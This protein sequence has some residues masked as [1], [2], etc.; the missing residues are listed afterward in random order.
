[1][2]H[3]PAMAA[4][5]HFAWMLGGDAG[6]SVRVD[7]GGTRPPRRVHGADPLAE[8]SLR[9]VC[10]E[11]TRWW[12]G[13]RRAYRRIGRSCGTRSRQRP[14]SSAVASS[15][16]CRR[17]SRGRRCTDRPPREIAG[18]PQVRW[19]APHG[20]RHPLVG[21]QRVVQP[22]RPILYLG[23]IGLAAFT[24]ARP[25]VVIPAVARGR[26]D[27]HF[28]ACIQDWW[29][30]DAFGGRRFDGTIPFFALGLAAFVHHAARLV[31]RHALGAVVALL[32]LFAVWNAAMF[33]S[34]TTAAFASARLSV[35]IAAGLAGGVSTAGSAIRSRIPRAC[36][37]RRATAYHRGIT[38]CC[39]PP[40]PR[41]SAAA[42]R[43]DGRRVGRE[44]LLG[45][46]G[47]APSAKETRRSAGPAS[48]SSL[49]SRSTTQRRCACR[50][51]AHAF[52]YAGARRKR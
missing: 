52:A 49:R 27:D 3:A 10:P 44:W 1:M 37:S 18:G 39:R 42:V 48:P 35:R 11:S 29:G 12:P 34:R 26:R 17:C 41:G 51:R 5:R 9:A 20:H 23:A 36:C 21:A 31:Q 4:A 7:V 32:V 8:R 33:A 28:N 30:S 2:S 13:R 38:T 46:G 19:L 16:S 45:E 24:I 40:L 50:F 43:A 6:Q 14:F 47:T 22:R 15:A 25:A